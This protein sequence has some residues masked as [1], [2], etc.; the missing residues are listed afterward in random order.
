MSLAKADNTAV[1][2]PVYNGEKTILKLVRQ[3][4]EF[5]DP[6]QIIIVDDGSEDKTCELCQKAGY[7]I[8][9]LPHNEGKGSALIAGFHE[10]LNRGFEFAFT[11]DSD[12]QHDPASIPRFFRKQNATLAEVIIGRRDFSPSAM[13]VPRILS[14]QTT[15]FIL[16]LMTGQRIYDSQCGYRLYKLEKIRNLK[17][18][19]KRYQ[20]ESEILIKLSRKLAKIDYVCIPTIYND[21]KSYISH[22]RDIKNFIKVILKNF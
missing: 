11:I 10:A 12:L 13:P 16:S 20:L 17:L 9:K 5:L 7:Q 21:E 18:E 15:S 14:N 4:S 1:I 6:A 2:I 3:I 8:I 22:F 19:S